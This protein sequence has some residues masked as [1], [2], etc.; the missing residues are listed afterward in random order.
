MQTFA[1][2]IQYD[3]KLVLFSSRLSRITISY[4][5]TCTQYPVFKQYLINQ[6]YYYYMYPV[7]RDTAR[8]RPYLGT[9]IAQMFTAR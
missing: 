2:L 3:T 8:V 5:G 6:T 9:C 7:S 4:P 1:M